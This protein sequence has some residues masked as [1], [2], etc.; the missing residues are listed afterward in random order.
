[1]QQ[2]QPLNS[3]SLEMQSG[4]DLSTAVGDPTGGGASMFPTE[5]VQYGAGG[6]APG[7]GQMEKKMSASTG[8]LPKLNPGLSSYMKDP[9]SASL[10]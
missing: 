8:S 3:T 4:C 1:M 5:P 6:G 7:S 2:Q 9:P 10:G